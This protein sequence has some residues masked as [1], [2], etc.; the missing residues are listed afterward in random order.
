[1]R[2]TRVP[3]PRAPHPMPSGARVTIK[4]LSVARR[5]HKH[6]QRTM[7]HLSPRTAPM[8]RDRS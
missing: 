6:L 2:Q 5:L 4:P 7:C 8:S 3:R 1:M